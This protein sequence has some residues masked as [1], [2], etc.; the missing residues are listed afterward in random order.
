MTSAARTAA[1]LS[2]RATRT[3]TPAR[4][5]PAGRA[6]AHP[7]GQARARA[8]ASA[9]LGGLA[10]VA[11]AAAVLGVA[12]AVGRGTGDDLDRAT[13]RDATAVRDR[14]PAALPVA[15]VLTPAPAVGV[16]PALVPAEARP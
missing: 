2:P 12:P 14:E 6:H 8:L 13:S 3:R 10:G 1:S 5:S 11:T 4:A 9:L 15:S 7:R 16:L